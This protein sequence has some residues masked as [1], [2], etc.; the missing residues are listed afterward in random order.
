M[1]YEVEGLARR[2]PGTPDDRGLVPSIRAPWGHPAPERAL[3]LPVTEM[4]SGNGV[5]LRCIS[6]ERNCGVRQAKDLARNVQ[7]GQR[8]TVGRLTTV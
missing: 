5:T 4:H 7:T 6:S 1:S 3:R 2:F 8:W